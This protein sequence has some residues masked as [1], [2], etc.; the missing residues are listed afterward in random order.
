[1]SAFQNSSFEILLEEVDQLY[2]KNYC[3]KE[4]IQPV[5]ERTI[6]SIIIAPLVRLELTTHWLT[7]S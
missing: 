1:M 6:M 5:R 3:N 7:A 2:D 4:N